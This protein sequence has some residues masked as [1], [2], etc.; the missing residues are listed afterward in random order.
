MT[1]FTKKKT[2][3]D[4]QQIEKEFMDK[5]NLTKD[6][7]EPNR[8]WINNEIHINILMSIQKS[9]DAAAKAIEEYYV[10]P[11]LLIATEEQKK[12]KGTAKS[13]GIG[14]FLE[15]AGKAAEKTFGP[16]G[17]Q[18]MQ[19]APNAT[20]NLANMG[21]GTMRDG[22]E[23]ARKMAMNDYDSGIK[24]LSTADALAGLNLNVGNQD[25]PKPKGRPPLKGKK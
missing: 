10:N 1:L 18:F 15:N 3:T 6:L 4:V 17:N 23:N 16:V 21:M 19:N 7:S 24:P 13:G 12:N 14:S 25:K 22:Q 20:E 8:Y 9:R 5:Y 11:K 2:L